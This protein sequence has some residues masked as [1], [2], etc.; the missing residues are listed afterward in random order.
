M[1]LYGYDASVYNAVQGSKHWVAWFNDPDDNMI[2]LINTVYTVGAIISGFFFG[3]P[4]ADYLG[5][6]AGMGIGAILVIISTL[7][8]IFSP[9]GNIGM[10][11]AGRIIIG[12]GQGLAL[13]K[14]PL[15]TFS[16]THLMTADLAAGSI[17]IGELAPQEIRGKIMSLWQTFYS[18]GS[19]I[20]CKNQSKCPNAPQQ[21]LTSPSLGKLWLPEE[22]RR[23]RKPRRMGLEDGR[24][25]PIACA[26]PHRRADTVHPRIPTLVRQ[27]GQIGERPRVAFPRARH[28]ARRC[29]R[30][31]HDPRGDRVREG[32]HLVVLLSPLE[33]SFRA[34]AFC[35]CACH[36]RRPTDH[37]PGLSQQLL[38]QDLPKSLQERLHHRPDQR[39]QRHLRNP[40]HAQRHL[41]RRPFRPALPLHRRRHRHGALHA[42]RRNGGNADSDSGRRLQVS[43][44]GRRDR[45]PA[46]PLH[47]LL[48]AV[49]GRYGL[50]LDL[51]GVLHEHPCPSGRHGFADAEHRQP[52]CEPILPDLSHSKSKSQC[53][54]TCCGL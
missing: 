3:G 47:L 33:G 26:Y 9:R 14:S 28:R 24:H 32:S 20:C 37:R 43:S 52:C 13:S 10:F 35:P 39:S 29:G 15:P 30:T 18:V 2:G 42:G 54:D 25:I 22:H 44:R 12:V 41:D 8:Q 51:R 21:M 49:L 45:L 27:E 1:V 4:V 5:R 23:Q 16:E 31:P 48:Q 53:M 50:D 11:M 36:Q 7:L 38:H 19:F 17:Y 40:V 46:L 6:R 34:Q